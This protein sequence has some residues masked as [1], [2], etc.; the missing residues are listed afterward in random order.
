MVVNR[1]MKDGKK[2]LAYQILYR[3]VKKIKPCMG[4]QFLPTRTNRLLMPDHLVLFLWRPAEGGWLH[5]IHA[6]IYP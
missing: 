6:H 1:I 5:S 4:V 3:A 2:S